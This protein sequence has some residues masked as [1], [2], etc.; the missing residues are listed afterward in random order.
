MMLLTRRVSSFHYSMGSGTTETKSRH[1]VREPR[2][3]AL[4]RALSWPKTNLGQKIRVLDLS[5]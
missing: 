2:I 4:S 5:E 1:L 3:A